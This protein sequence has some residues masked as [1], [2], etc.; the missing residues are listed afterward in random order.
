MRSCVWAGGE[1]GVGR[2][3]PAVRRTAQRGHSESEQ[4]FFCVPSH[5]FALENK[6]RSG[7]KS[8]VTVRTASWPPS[9]IKSTS[10]AAS[11]PPL[12]P[13]DPARSWTG[14]KGLEEMHRALHCFR[15]RRSVIRRNLSKMQLNSSPKQ[16]DPLKIRVSIPPTG[17]QSQ[18][19][20]GGW[21]DGERGKWGSAQ[22]L[23]P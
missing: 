16:S 17:K 14:Q 18:R 19:G 9:G 20:E 12:A 8:L 7:A 10:A 11:S 6:A 13:L 23:L 21:G 2:T 1:A 5:H 3:S 15:K 4:F 22:V